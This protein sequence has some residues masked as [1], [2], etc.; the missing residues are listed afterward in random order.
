MNPITFNYLG[1]SSSLIQS[2][3]GS[4]SPLLGFIAKRDTDHNKD[5][6]PWDHSMF[7]SFL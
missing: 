5:T 2:N 4:K 7:P 3:K 1:N 6:R